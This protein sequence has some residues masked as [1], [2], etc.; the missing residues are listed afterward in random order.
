MEVFSNFLVPVVICQQLSHLS[1]VVIISGQIW[2]DAY[3]ESLPAMSCW[4]LI[5]A[6]ISSS[7][8]GKYLHYSETNDTLKT[9]L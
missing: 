8:N 1:E 3:P 2:R 9:A 5:D 7:D 6:S 4:K